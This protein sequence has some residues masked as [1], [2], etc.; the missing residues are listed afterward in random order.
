[1]PAAKILR[2]E[3]TAAAEYSSHRPVRIHATNGCLVA[4]GKCPENL[5]DVLKVEKVLI[6]QDV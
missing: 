6:D 2:W 4:I 5:G 1:V 3:G